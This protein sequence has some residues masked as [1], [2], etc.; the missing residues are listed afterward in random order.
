MNTIQYSPEPVRYM[1][2]VFPWTPESSTQTASRSLQPFLQCSLGDRPTDRPSRYNIMLQTYIT[3]FVWTIFSQRR[4]CVLVCWRNLVFYCTWILV[5]SDM[6]RPTCLSNLKFLSAFTTKIW[7]GIQSAENLTKGR[8]APY[9]MWYTTYKDKWRGRCG[10]L[11]N[12]LWTLYR[13]VFTFSHNLHAD[14]DRHTNRKTTE[15]KRH[16]E[17]VRDK[18]DDSLAHL[19]P[20]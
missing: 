2:H 8:I 17:T 16:I 12:L 14:M 4:W 20:L 18:D 3:T 11:S 1:Q 15:R 13:V 6:L 10:L 9:K 5:Y 19:F 7:K